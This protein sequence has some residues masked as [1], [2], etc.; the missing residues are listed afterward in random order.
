MRANRTIGLLL[1]ASFA[2]A[3]G[4][5][6][7][8][9]LTVGDAVERALAV[10]PEVVAAEARRVEAQRG[11]DE[12]EASRGPIASAR[13]AGN[14]YSDPNLVS[15]IHSF[16]PRDFPPFERTLVQGSVDL[17]Y[18]L[19]DAGVQR[20]RRRQATERE[21]AAA[22]A[23]AGTGQGVAARVVATFADVRARAEV[24][25][26]ERARVEAVR[27]ELG[28]VSLL[29]EAGRAAELD[30]LRAEAAL[31]G[32]EAAEVSAGALLDVAERELAR[33]LAVEPEATRADRLAPI[34][35]SDADPGARA[36]LE[37]R[38]VASSPAVERARRDAAAAEAARALAHAA[39]LPELR[40][41][42]ALQ[43][44]GDS[45]FDFKTE[46]VAGLLLTVPLWDGGATGARVARAE[47]AQTT[48]VAAVAAAELDARSAV[49]HALAA[50]AEADARAA[51]LTRAADRLAEVARV[52]KLRLDVGAGTQVDY[53]DAEAELASTRADLTGARTGALLARVEL[54]RAT[55][56]LGTD[57]IRRTLEEQP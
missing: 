19:Y 4:A 56:E 20:E 26:A 25:A 16:D 50:L 6:A 28:R 8:Q 31:A 46:W 41:V 29:V 24:L 53:L 11:L 17:R 39:Y 10:H 13:L 54:A 49:D 21:G 42:G 55:G 5:A 57:W 45:S 30:R 37:A 32:A 1:A 2:S 33:L 44:Y 23:L 34:A 18:T 36:D 52:E 12:A 9:L 22:A 27:Q 14:R 43:E 7:Q 35:K 40:A 47:A 51:A 3:G 15:P 48:A 38:A